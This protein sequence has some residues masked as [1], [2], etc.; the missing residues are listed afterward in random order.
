MQDVN[1]VFFTSGT[2]VF[3]HLSRETRLFF[4]RMADM[5]TSMVSRLVIDSFDIEETAANV[6][7]NEKCWYE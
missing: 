4:H 7:E 2:Q 5:S 3:Q 1:I 6:E